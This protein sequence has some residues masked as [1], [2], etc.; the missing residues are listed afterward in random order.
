MPELPEVETIRLGLLGRVCNK[1]IEHVEIR[2]ERIILR[3]E[4][5]EMA[6]ALG[7][8]IIRDIQRRGKFLLF[9]FDELRLL[10]HLGMSGQ[11]TY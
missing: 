7:G 2:C 4:P 8:Q 10:V 6:A 3:P 9:K 1:R 11:L 5:H